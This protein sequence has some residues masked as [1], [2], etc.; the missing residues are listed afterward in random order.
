[1]RAPPVSQT[2]FWGSDLMGRTLAQMAVQWWHQAIE[3]YSG[4]GWGRGSSLRDSL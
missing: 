3:R 4:G 2:L 1:M